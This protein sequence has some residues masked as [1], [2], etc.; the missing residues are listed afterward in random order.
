MTFLAVVG[1]YGW[2]GLLLK[3]TSIT[4]VLCAP[5]VPDPANA[6]AART[7]SVPDERLETSL[8]PDST[9]IE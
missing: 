5:K 1:V 7:V 8:E 9:A 2:T 4:A 3:L 6:A